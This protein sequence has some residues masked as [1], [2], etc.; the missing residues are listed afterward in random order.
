VGRHPPERFRRKQTLEQGHLGARRLLADLHPDLVY[1]LLGRRSGRNDYRRIKC[2]QKPYNGA[3]HTVRFPYR[4]PCFC[5]NSI[6]VPDQVAQLDLLAPPGHSQHFARKLFRAVP[7]F[8]ER[9]VLIRLRFRA[10]CRN[11]LLFQLL[12]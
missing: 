6:I 11:I 8:P 9:V 4:V 7:V 3:R 12:V 10:E 5:G 1:D 2:M